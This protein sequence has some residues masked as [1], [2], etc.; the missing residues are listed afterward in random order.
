MAFSNPGTLAE[1]PPTSAN[2][3]AARFTFG[4]RCFHHTNGPVLTTPSGVRGMTLGAPRPAGST[5]MATHGTPVDSMR[6]M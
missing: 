5:T 2:S 4:L 6:S 3:T 1:T